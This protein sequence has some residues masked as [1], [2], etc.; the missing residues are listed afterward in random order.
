MQGL[1]KLCGGFLG[2]F[3]DQHES[4]PASDDE[5]AG[6][7][8]LYMPRDYKRPVKKN[9]NRF[10]FLIRSGEWSQ[11]LA[12]VT[13]ESRSGTEVTRRVFEGI[14]AVKK[15]IAPGMM[16][17]LQS[18]TT[19]H[20]IEIISCKLKEQ[21][22]MQ[23]LY[24]VVVLRLSKNELTLL[25]RSMGEEQSKD[26]KKTNKQ[27]SEPHKKPYKLETFCC[28]HNKLEIIEPGVL[29]GM[30]VAQLLV[31]NLSHN[32]L[33][34]LPYDFGAQASNLKF[35]DLSHNRIFVLP[36][37]VLDCRKLIAINIDHN[38]VEQLPN[39]IGLLRGLRKLFASYNQLSELPASIGGCKLL[40]K[41]RLVSNQIQYMPHS[42][43][44]LWSARGGCLDELLVEGN[45]LIQPSITAFQMGGLERA[46]RL[47]GEWVR[48]QQRRQKEA[49]QQ[50]EQRKKAEADALTL[51][52]KPADAHEPVPQILDAVADTN[53]AALNLVV[54]EV[55]TP[56][57]RQ[58]AESIPSFSQGLSNLEELL[59]SPRASST[60]A[61]TDVTDAQAETEADQRD[62][63]FVE[64]SKGN[65]M[66]GDSYYFSH[67]Q[68]DV[69]GC[70]QI[71]N[72]ESVLLMRKKHAFLKQ[73]KKA[74]LAFANIED[75]R[76]EGVPEHLRELF[77]H[78]FDE[79]KLTQK[80][81]VLD[82]DLYFCS[83]VYGS[84][85]AFTS[86]H[87]LWDK[88]EVGE[89]GYMSRDEWQNLC[90][91]VKTKL[92]KPVVGQLWNYMTG[93]NGDQLEKP[94]F[95]AG[96]HIH[97]TEVSDPH[98]KHQTK[99][100][101]L[102]YY[103]MGVEELQQRLKLRMA[104]EADLATDLQN[105]IESRSL[106]RAHAHGESS[107][108]AAGFTLDYSLMQ[109]PGE[110]PMQ[111]P[112]S[113]K[114][115][116]ESQERRDGINTKAAPQKLSGLT[117]SDEG[118]SAPAALPVQVS[119]FRA[120]EAAESDFEDAESL[121]SYC[122]SR[123]AASSEASF[124]AQA[125]VE[126]QE[127]WEKREA[128]MEQRMLHE[129]NQA[130]IVDSDEALAQLMQLPPDVICQ[131][132]GLIENAVSSSGSVK[133]KR[134]RKKKVKK[135][136]PHKKR[137]VIHDSRFYTDVLSV[138]RAIREAHRNIPGDDF[139]GLVLY[140]FKKLKL[141]KHA[142][143]EDG[144][145]IYLHADDPCFKNST[146]LGNINPYV[147]ALMFDMGLVRLNDIHWVW[148][149]RHWDSANESSIWL[150]HVVPAHCP[151]KN[152][153]RLHDM[154]ELFKMCKHVLVKE[155]KDFAGHM[156]H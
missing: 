77:I 32:N 80:V 83:L 67:V 47:F 85:S 148:P 8:D 38:E 33:Q 95:V 109:G 98:I 81:P 114:Q 68:G 56:S 120:G 28:D 7:E 134:D 129:D 135:K 155:G 2:Q 126:E 107:H 13:V 64:A 99:T 65:L 137:P 151:G 73:L 50:E 105:R 79:T 88:F 37:S 125:A 150:S 103:G 30:Q 87:A 92:S 11:F 36:E 119:I 39:G 69:E 110:R 17:K 104:E 154:I 59:N 132:A 144:A 31:L 112:K 48:E 136:K 66:S 82:L 123:S 102:S 12:T 128:L 84:K 22:P 5:D 27:G 139:K 60:V 143:H 117:E 78:D 96:W 21:P 35:L 124:D 141:F 86:I 108:Q 55:T 62:V 4:P 111:D 45:P 138:R 153:Q 91:R 6:D 133:S 113:I 43:L 23:E 16:K 61:D 122:L 53:A 41:I 116:R 15:D 94:D 72:A 9:K 93:G 18:M 130:I 100:L 140:M 46:L 118:P 97:D 127:E 1:K 90:T 25:S 29:S 42:L 54:G 70:I 14:N 10:P 34:M 142:A 131:R 156:R 26:K 76:P 19:I 146:G 74:A 71:R 75:A 44:E 145:L 52:D 63:I 24:N 40:E 149:A 3:H 106:S 58:S 152:M 147:E 101:K 57:N 115:L 121:D 49:E 51:T 20:T 89:K